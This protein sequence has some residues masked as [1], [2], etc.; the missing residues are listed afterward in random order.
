MRT[1]LR[2]TSA[3][4]PFISLPLT[5]LGRRLHRKTLSGVPSETPK[6]VG[7]HSI[8]VMAPGTV[9]ESILKK[10]K[11]DEEWA[12]KRAADAQ[13]KKESRKKLRKDIFK[14]AEAYVKEYR[15]QVNLYC[16]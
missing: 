8:G 12:A 11:R 2:R 1:V 13:A 7:E 16:F 9:P 3:V 14:R 4:Q 5:S 15:S 10:R 6:A